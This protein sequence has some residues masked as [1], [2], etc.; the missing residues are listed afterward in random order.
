[1]DNEEEA[2][3]MVFPDIQKVE[4]TNID[5]SNDALTPYEQQSAQI[6]KNAAKKDTPFQT[7]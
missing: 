3:D 1:M 4:K 6:H 7:I 2:R 5:I